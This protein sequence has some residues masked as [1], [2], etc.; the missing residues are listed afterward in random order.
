[1]GRGVHAYIENVDQVPLSAANMKNLRPE[2]ISN[3]VFSVFTP[4][5]NNI[6]RP[7]YVKFPP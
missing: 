7:L 1:M 3:F 6:F 4:P 2:N 5:V